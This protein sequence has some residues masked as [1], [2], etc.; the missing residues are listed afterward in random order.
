MGVFLFP[1]PE[2]ISM[3]VMEVAC[4]TSCVR[5]AIC[6]PGV[7]PASLAGVILQLASAP[8]AT[9]KKKLNFV[10]LFPGRKAELGGP[11]KLLFNAYIP[12]L[13]LPSCSSSVFLLLVFLPFLSRLLSQLYHL[14]THHRCCHHHVRHDHCHRPHHHRR[15]PMGQPWDNHGTTMGQPMGQPMGQLVS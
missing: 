7:A 4:Q 15:Q 3:S 5:A 13:S 9:T 1:E 2:S 14:P 12:S 6:V 8:L 11:S 10:V